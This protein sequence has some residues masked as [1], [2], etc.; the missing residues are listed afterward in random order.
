MLTL[1]DKCFDIEI[2]CLAS[3]QVGNIAQEYANQY[4]LLFATEENPVGYCDILPMRIETEGPPVRQKAYRAPLAKRA[5]IE[6]EIQKMAEYGVI[7]PSS[8]SY[9]SPVVL[10]TKPDGSIRFCVAYMELN[11]TIK[12]DCFPLPFVSDVLALQSRLYLQ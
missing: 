10:V 6:Q 1:F 11:K 7:R 9:A 12:D 2:T 4:L 8:S 5:V 3:G